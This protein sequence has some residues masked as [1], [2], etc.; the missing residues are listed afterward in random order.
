MHVYWSFELVGSGG[1]QYISLIITSFPFPVRLTKSGTGPLWPQTD[2]ILLG[3][4]VF[5]HFSY[6]ENWMYLDRFPKE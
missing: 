2:D 5:V 6:P 4:K 1:F 3:K